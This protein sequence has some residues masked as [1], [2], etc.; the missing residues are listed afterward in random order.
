MSRIIAYHI[1]EK[2]R[3]VS[4]WS[5]KKPFKT[6]GNPFGTLRNPLEP[7]GTLWISKE[8]FTLLAP[9]VAP[10]PTRAPSSSKGR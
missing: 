9:Q 4:F 10:R 2:S 3:S 6:L 1:G 8:P 7:Q 5:P